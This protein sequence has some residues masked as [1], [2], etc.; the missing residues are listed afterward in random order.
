MEHAVPNQEPDPGVPVPT[1]NFNK[2]ET[3][4]FGGASQNVP[5]PKKLVLV[6]EEKP[7]INSMGRVLVDKY[8]NMIAVSPFEQQVAWPSSQANAQK[9][10][11]VNLTRTSNNLRAS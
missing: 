4:N 10:V 11:P 6:N 8:K 9:E 5:L 3:A 7:I 2:M 1:L